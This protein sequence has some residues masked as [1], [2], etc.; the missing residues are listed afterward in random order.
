MFT[1]LVNG[2]YLHFKMLTTQYRMHDYLLKVPNTL[3]YNNM[4]NT[5]YRN[6]TTEN[7]FLNRQ[8]PLLFINHEF[9]E[10]HYGSSYV[11]KEESEM[12]IKVLNALVAQTY[13]IKKFGFVSPY[14]G[15]IQ[16]MKQ[17]LMELGVSENVRTI[18]SWQGREKEFMI[19]SAV[20]SNDRGK[21]GFLENYRRI[22]VALTR[23]Q[24]GLI[25]IGNAETLS[26]NEKWQTLIS[27]F[28]VTGSYVEGVQAAINKIKELCATLHQPQD[29]VAGIDGAE[30]ESEEAQPE[31]RK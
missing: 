24:H 16:R 29:Y 13:D 22:N 25:I 10:Q 17:D 2:K 11:N 3:F 15:Q 27:Y 5:G 4:I 18:D 9:E 30:D 21:I 12:I 7:I 20:R 19:F 28:R 23:A 14:Q 31:E 1:R 26:T 8:R 6:V